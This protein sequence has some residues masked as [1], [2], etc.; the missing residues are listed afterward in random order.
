MKKSKNH[1]EIKHTHTHTC[2]VKVLKVD[3]E[4]FIITLKFG[5]IVFG[6]EVF[7]SNKSDFIVSLITLKFGVVVLQERHKKRMRKVYP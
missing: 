2:S 1:V 4:S 3:H 7:L 6:T 5:G